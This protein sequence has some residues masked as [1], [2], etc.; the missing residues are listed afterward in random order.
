M[1]RHNIL[2]NDVA[3]QNFVQGCLAL[4]AEPLGTTRYSTYDYFAFWHHRAMNFMTPPGNSAG[5]NAAHAGPVFGPWHRFLL[6]VFE[7]Q[8]RRVL[9]ED[10]FRLPYWDW[11]ADAASPAGSPLWGP[12]VL[13]G[14]GNPVR[15][16]PFRDGSGFNIRLTQDGNSDD[17]MDVDRPL[18]RGFNIFGTTV[19]SA[20]E[21]TNSINSFPFYERQ[22][23]N[24]DVSSFR[25]D[26]EIPLHST[27]HRFV[28]GDMMT[29]TSPNDPVFFLHHCNIDRIWAR[30]QSTYP[31]ALY[32]PRQTA[33]DT[34]RFHRE[35][36]RMHT[37]LDINLTPADI[38][39][40]TVYY[41]YDIL[42]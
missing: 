9:N 26:L 29:T 42:N 19:P 30:W 7:N 2:T 25:W 15:S 6:I 22:P 33:P 10:D 23:Y 17:W 20:T 5:R 38:L 39:D 27:V 4:K 14:S 24:N 28:G 11:A 8:I 16:G 3:R 41:D 1:I 35:D 36:D 13:G 18:R 32:L 21:V 12:D 34:Y 40:Y 37:F 31:Q